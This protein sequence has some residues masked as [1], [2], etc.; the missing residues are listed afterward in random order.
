VARLDFRL[1][2]PLEVCD[3]GRSLPLGGAKQRAVLARLVLEAGRVVSSDRLVEE[4]WPERPPGRP[5]TAIQGYVSE[6]RKL[7]EPKRRPAMPFQVL[8]T[9]GPGYLLRLEPEQLD[10]RRFERLFEQGKEALA[11]GRAEVASRMLR[12]GLSLWRG[13]A[14]ADFAYESWAQGAIARLEELRLACL[15]ERLEADLALGRHGELVGELEALIS[16]HPLRER[17][18]GQLMLALYRSGRQAEALEAYQQAR[19]SL[20]EELGIEPNTELQELNRAIL[21]QEAG[22]AVEPP[23]KPPPPSLP[24]PATPLVGRR[25]ELAELQALL[26]RPEVR[27]LTLT[28]AGGSGKTRLALAL[29]EERVEASGD[30]VCFCELAPIADPALV[31]PTVAQALGLRDSGGEPLLERLTVHLRDRELLLCLDNL[32]QLLGVAPD[33]AAL[34]AAAPALRLLVT[35]RERLQLQAEHE[36]PVEPLPLP[37]PAALPS[38]E[39]LAQVDAVALFLQRAQAVKPDFR[40]T[41]KNAFAVAAICRRLDGLPLALELAAA[42]IKLLSPE[43][44][45]ARLEHSLELL[46]GGARDLPARQQTLRATIAWSYQ[47]LSEPEQRLFAR[48]SVFVGGCTLEAAEQVCKAELETLASLVNKSLLRQ[49]EDASGEPRFSMLETVREYA[50]ERLQQSG[51]LQE[52]APRQAAYFLDLAEQAETEIW[53][54]RQEVW[55]ERLESEHDNLR[56]A[57]SWALESGAAESALRLAGALEP[58]WEA[59]GHISEGRRLLAEAVATAPGA[60]A[61]VR[62]KAL[63]GASRLARIHGEHAYEQTLLEESVALHRKGGDERGLIFSLSHLGTVSFWLGHHERAITLGEESVEL[64]R[65][66][67]DRWFLGM[68]LNNLGCTLIEEGA[69]A[70]ARELIEES[71]S[72]RREIGEKR[73]VAVTASSLAELALAEGDGERA[74]PLLEEALA[75]ARDL[76]HLPFIAG[77]LAHLGL[78]RIY[79]EDY[80]HGRRLLEEGLE[81]CQDVGDKATASQC[82]SGLAAL[83]A[84]QGAFLRS[85][86]LWGAAEALREETG[87]SLSPP[88]RP[89]AEGC[90]ALAR[91]RLDEEGWRE[92]EAAGQAMA[93]DQ[94]VAYA[95]ETEPAAAS[96]HPAH[97][98]E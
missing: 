9:E 83:A 60:P 58:F 26:A 90:L 37:D 35:S 76:G 69:H 94:A 43:A 40:L 39:A 66:L 4:L 68:A 63:F 61:S 53:G 56:A 13:P 12:E 92:A 54:P 77:F 23:P 20:V 64:A 33:L 93:L 50:H 2:G 62:A 79:E 7:L 52:T 17:L 98:P 45:L 85:A 67:G 82:L 28:G 95:L 49:G 44:L 16:E 11:E 80:G 10:L 14:L 18:R 71:L 96:P 55:L 97:H 57:L 75:L 88:E 36:Y 51:E 87:M 22:L 29:C 3:G 72:L 42:R 34:L 32:E 47:L 70:R 86:R 15:E 30:G 91:A 48:L 5:Q 21:R 6:L 19:R 65:E 46:T 1:L 38:L 25:R 8:T 59:H 27:L 74:T 24:A 84:V 89:L 31:L 73:G 78:A 81:R 41:E